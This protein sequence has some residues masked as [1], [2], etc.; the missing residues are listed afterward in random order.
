MEASVAAL[1]HW[2]RVAE[3]QDAQWEA[4]AERAAEADQAKILQMARDDCWMRQLVW[5]YHERGAARERA[6]GAASRAVP[7]TSRYPAAVPGEI[8]R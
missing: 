2:D 4:T 7:G 1:W 8:T 6:A 5:Q 3:Y